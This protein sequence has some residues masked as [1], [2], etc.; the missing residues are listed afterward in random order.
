MLGEDRLGVSARSMRLVF[1][2]VIGAAGGVCL[3]LGG[4]TPLDEGSSEFFRASLLNVAGF[5]L[6]AATIGVLNAGRLSRKWLLGINILY[7]TISFAAVAL[8]LSTSMGFISER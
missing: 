1:A 2:L 7:A 5:V 8:S 6:L 4:K 3:L